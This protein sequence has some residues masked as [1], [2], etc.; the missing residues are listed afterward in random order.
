MTTRRDPGV[1]DRPAGQQPSPMPKGSASD[2]RNVHRAGS[3]S[4]AGGHSIA[5]P[6]SPPLRSPSLGGVA[7]KQRVGQ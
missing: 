3:Q 7:F 5:A 6:A 4:A 2:G 1:I